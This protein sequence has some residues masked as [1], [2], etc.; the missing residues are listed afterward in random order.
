LHFVTLK[1]L[2]RL[3]KLRLKKAREST[4]SAK[5]RVDAFHLQLE[6]M[7][8]EVFH[9][10]KEVGKCHEFKSK[11]EDIELVAIE[12]FYQEAPS[13][14]SKV[15]VTKNDPHKLTLARL[16]WEFE[17]RKRLSEQC[18]SL[19]Q[20]REKT[21][22]DIVGK[23]KQ[24]ESLA[25]RLQTILE[26]TQPLQE[27]LNVPL[28]RITFQKELA[29]LLPD[30]L[31]ILYSQLKAYIEACGESHVVDSSMKVAVGGEIEDAR[32]FGTKVKTGSDE[33]LEDVD[34]DSDLDNDDELVN[35][36]R[37]TTASAQGIGADALLF[38]HPLHILL[39]IDHISVTFSYLVAM[40][41]VMVGTKS[42]LKEENHSVL[43]VDNLLTALFPDD[44]G[45]DSPNMVNV[46]QSKSVSHYQVA[47]LGKP[48]LWA[49][50]LAGLDFSGA[51][52]S[53][54]KSFVNSA[55]V[56]QVFKAIKD[57]IFHR[58]QLN[59]LLT[60]LGKGEF[61]LSVESRA[62]FPATMS[63]RLASWTPTTYE[64][65]HKVRAAN[66]LLTYMDINPKKMSFFK[67]VL[68]RGAAKLT[69]FAIIPLDYPCTAPL[70]TLELN[71]HG[72]YDRETSQDIRQM[73]AEVNV[74]YKELPSAHKIDLLAD[75]LRRLA[76]QLDLL[77]EIDG[78]LLSQGRGSRQV[79]A[80]A[81]ASQKPEYPAEKMIPQL[82]KGRDRARPL[83][84]D[85]KT[86]FYLH[87]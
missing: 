81:P 64:E 26:A 78:Q 12:E 21:S 50:R 52:K 39:T 4:N 85:A 44:Y 67:A 42:S 7:L 5:Q 18:R 6:N 60:S 11:D 27:E 3:D 55:Y 45:D 8:Y 48:Y 47:E 65:C 54:P 19:E 61:P 16:E 2:N 49:Q 23:Q 71:W 66:Q 43:A 74:F 63:S 62:A 59:E 87:R 70:F 14:I 56:D 32:H 41:I 86:Q 20:S 25:P 9:L 22:A 77:T 36:K 28:E 69:A 75:Q 83:K 46:Y 30:P 38:K 17:Q 57:R 84:Y 80:S 73:E 82:I 34:S 76:L 58:L 79:L 10:R 68:Q 37:T 24:L 1:K 15:E 40:N 31:Y 33:I 29:A 13:N 51:V 72:R 35:K 53:A